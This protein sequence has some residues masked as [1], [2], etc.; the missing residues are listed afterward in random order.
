MTADG[1]V[2]AQRRPTT[3]G[4]VHPKTSKRLP[5]GDEV[6]QHGGG[7]MLAGPIP[8]HHGYS[9]AV[10]STSYRVGGRGDPRWLGSQTADAAGGLHFFHRATGTLRTAASVATEDEDLPG[11]TPSM[12]KA[13]RPRRSQ[14]RAAR[15]K[16]AVP[17]AAPPRAPP[18]PAAVRHTKRTAW[19]AAQVERLAQ[20]SAA[21]RPPPGLAAAKDFISAFIKRP[22]AQF[23]NAYALEALGTAQADRM[24][25][26]QERELCARKKPD[27]RVVLAAYNLL[28]SK[29][30]ERRLSSD[31]RSRALR[32]NQK[33]RPPRRLSASQRE[34]RQAALQETSE[35]LCPKQPKQRRPQK[36]PAASELAAARDYLAAFVGRPRAAFGPEHTAHALEKALAD[37]MISRAEQQLILRK[38]SPGQMVAAAGNLLRCRTFEQRLESDLRTRGWADTDRGGLSWRA[39]LPTRRVVTAEQRTAREAMLQQ[40]AER[41]CPTPP[42]RPA[43]AAAAAATSCG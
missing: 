17:R 35:R 1:G 34:T 15:R 16:H 30:F 26:A 7:G 22:R 41:L 42:P 28:R 31:I 13:G 32:R 9:G 24:I 18:A 6:T 4:F 36:E 3:G 12:P 27:E 29:Q 8:G 37:G 11:P 21:P 10:G 20:Q 5:P 23:C 14:R 33:P 25:T 2:V 39:P 19:V 43:S 38:R 40:V